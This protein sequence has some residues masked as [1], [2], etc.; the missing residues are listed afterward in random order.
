ME[1]ERRVGPRLENRRRKKEEEKRKGKSYLPLAFTL[2]LKKI[3][4][5]VD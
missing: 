5:I 3:A 4:H 1:E 2:R